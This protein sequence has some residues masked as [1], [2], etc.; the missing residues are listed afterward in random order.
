MAALVGLEN[1]QKRLYTF[2]RLHLP[3]LSQPRPSLTLSFRGHPLGG[4]K[5]ESL[6]KNVILCI[7]GANSAQIHEL[8]VSRNGLAL[9]HANSSPGAV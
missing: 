8:L 2:S 3:R 6:D 4:I 9:S 7:A 5:F 1:N